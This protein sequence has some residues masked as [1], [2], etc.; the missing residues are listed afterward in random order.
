MVFSQEKG[1]KSVWDL[2]KAQQ[3]GGA[4]EDMQ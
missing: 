2:D 1:F 3:H 4:E